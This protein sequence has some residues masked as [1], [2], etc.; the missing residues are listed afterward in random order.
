MYYYTI[1]FTDTVIDVCVGVH[2][3]STIDVNGILWLKSE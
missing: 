1:N 3:V 2:I